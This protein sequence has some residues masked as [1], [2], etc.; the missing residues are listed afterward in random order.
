MD[1]NYK[2][3]ATKYKEHHELPTDADLKPHLYPDFPLERARL[4]HVWWLNGLFSV[5]T[6][7]YGY[8]VEWNIAIPLVLQFISMIKPIETNN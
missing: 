7:V 3:E 8:S 4:G 6:A 2:K 1:W 5:T